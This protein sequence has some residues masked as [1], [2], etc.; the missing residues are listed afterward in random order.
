MVWV[1][2]RV[3]HFALLHRSAIPLLPGGASLCI[4]SPAAAW[5]SVA[6]RCSASVGF[7]DVRSPDL[8]RSPLGGTGIS[9]GAAP[10]RAAPRTRPPGRCTPTGA[11]RRRAEAACPM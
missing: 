11:G 10:S 9:H 2:V 1:W 7:P 5:P 4:H 8:D 3:R 6:H